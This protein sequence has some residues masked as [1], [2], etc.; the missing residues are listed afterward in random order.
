MALIAP[1]AAWVAT[2]G[3]LRFARNDDG[4]IRLPHPLLQWR[5]LSAVDFQSGNKSLL[6]NLY[7]PELPHLFLARLLLFQKLP[8]AGDVAPIAFRGHVLAQ[9]AHR[10]AGNDLSADCRLNGDLKK[11]RRNE[12]FEYFEHGATSS[13][14]VL[15][16]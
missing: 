2:T 7:L 4:G 11:M 5:L 16:L 13:V 14:V 10:L 6:G 9:R 3:L 12:L 1:P 8:L 15:S